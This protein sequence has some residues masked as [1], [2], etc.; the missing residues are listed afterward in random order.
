[1]KNNRIARGQVSARRKDRALKVLD[2]LLD[3]PADHVRQKAAAALLASAAREEDADERDPAAPIV[4]QITPWNCRPMWKDS[5]PILPRFGITG[6][7]DQQVVVIPKYGPFPYAGSGVKIQPEEFYA[8]FVA[9]WW[10]QYEIRVVERTA[11]RAAIHQRHIENGVAPDVVANLLQHNPHDAIFQ[12]VID[13]PR[14][15]PA[16]VGCWFGRRPNS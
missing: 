1:M 5:K 9:A 7:P 6:D 4:L 14:Q 8:P 15:L 2:D 16:P 12:C 3:S 13:E 11:S 10:R